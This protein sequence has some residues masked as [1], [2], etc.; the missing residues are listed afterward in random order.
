M[1]TVAWLSS[2][3][4]PCM[5]AMASACVRSCLC[6]QKDSALPEQRHTAFYL[7]HWQHGSMLSCVLHFTSSP[8]PQASPTFCSLLVELTATT[9]AEDSFSSSYT[10]IGMQFNDVS[11]IQGSATSLKHEHTPAQVLRLQHSQTATQHTLDPEK[12]RLLY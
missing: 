9:D 6:C 2:H 11:E 7:K 3:V 1:G 8:A 10:H 12:H 4:S 5:C